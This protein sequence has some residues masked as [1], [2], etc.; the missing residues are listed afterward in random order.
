MGDTVL[1][2][3]R[4]CQR[5]KRYLVELQSLVTAQMDFVQPVEDEDN[6]LLLT[7]MSGKVKETVPWPFQVGRVVW[8]QERLQG[9]RGRQGKSRAYQSE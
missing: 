4:K 1:W 9:A 6:S 2:S 8:A 3:R 7:V 5:D